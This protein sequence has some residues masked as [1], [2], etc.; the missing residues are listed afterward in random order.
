MWLYIYLLQLIIFADH[1]NYTGV[2]INTP[3]NEKRTF[4]KIIF[5]G[6]YD[7]NDF[8]LSKPYKDDYSIYNFFIRPNSTFVWNV[9]DNTP[10]KNR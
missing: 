8:H 5:G 10:Y 1:L 3:L 2:R 9:Y 7:K 4:R 6:G